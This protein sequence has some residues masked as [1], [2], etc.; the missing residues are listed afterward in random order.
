[1]VVVVVVARAD[2]M[3]MAVE[4]AAVACMVAGFWLQVHTHIG[5][6]LSRWQKLGPTVGV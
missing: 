3:L 6:C 5:K 4:L 1:M 2:G